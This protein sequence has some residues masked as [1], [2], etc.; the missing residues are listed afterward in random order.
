MNQ[1]K[2]EAWTRQD[3]VEKNA[4]RQF[5]RSEKR[6]TKTTQRRQHAA[7]TL[8]R[9]AKEEYLDQIAAE[10]AELKRL[11]RQKDVDRARVMMFQQNGCVRKFNSV[12]LS[13]HV[14]REN[15]AL[16]KFRKEKLRAAK[17][18]EKRSEE[19]ASCRQGEALRQEPQKAGQKQRDITALAA[20]QTQQMKEK[21][22]LK[23]VEMQQKKDERQRLMLLN[24]LH[25]Q[26]AA[27]Q[28][29][30]RAESKKKHLEHQLEDI[31]NRKLQREEEARK[32]AEEEMKQV[33]P[34]SGRKLQPGNN[35]RAGKLQMLMDQLAVSKRQQREEAN[36]SEAEAARQQEEKEERAA[37][38]R[39][40]AAHREIRMQERQQME[41]AEQKSNL[42]WFLAQ[43]ESDRLFV[44]EQEREAQRRRE[45][46]ME[47]REANMAMA[48]EKRGQAEQLR[49]EEREAAERSAGQAA[50][51]ERQLQNYILR[52]LQAAAGSQRNVLLAAANTLGHVFLVDGEELLLQKHQEMPGLLAS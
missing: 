7:K 37:V 1:P 47:C 35:E 29:Q 34:D 43:R 22:Q 31:A 16:I 12:L 9:Q 14:Q 19:E 3:A 40:I 49:E 51:T 15:E 5:N 23:E 21:Q 26:E 10:E 45:K 27:A 36:I 39:S 50:Q 44:E 2:S 28:A 13:I 20:Y 4:Q 25:A 17:E 24:K 52:E 33:R 41:E 11:D 30:K 46:A 38:L 48:A 18:Q 42:D 6:F 32:R 8:E